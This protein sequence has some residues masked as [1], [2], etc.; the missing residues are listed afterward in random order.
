MRVKA[1]ATGRRGNRIIVAFGGKTILVEISI[2]VSQKKR[3]S[4][5]KKWNGPEPCGT[6]RKGIL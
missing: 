3:E 5:L 4:F 6:E 1:R 2:K